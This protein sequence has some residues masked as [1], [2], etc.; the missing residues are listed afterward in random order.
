MEWE[1]STGIS[2]SG[3]QK[4]A[5]IQLAL[6]KS[7]YLLHVYSLKKLPAFFQNIL[8]SQ[9]IVKLGR[10]IGADFSK[11]A[12][13][14]PEIIPPT[15]HKKI[16]KGTIELGQLAFKKNVVP[17]GKAS[18]AAIVAAT[19]QKYLSKESRASEW[20]TITL[21]DDQ[22]QYAALDAYVALMIWEVL[23]NFEEA[24]KPLSSATK[25]GELV[26]LYVRKQEVA[27]GIIL[28]QPVSFL[29]QNPLPNEEPISLNVST[30]KTRALIQID[31]ILAPNC[32][33][34]HHRQSLKNL[35]NDEGSFKVVVS[36][37]SLRTRSDKEPVTIPEPLELR[38]IGTIKAIQP[39]SLSTEDIEDRD[40][41]IESDDDDEEDP[42]SE[43]GIEENVERSSGFTQQPSDI[44]PS[45]ILADVFHEIDKV[46]RTISKK[47][48]LCRKF[49]TAFSDTLLV[50]DEND[51]KVVSEILEKKGVSFNKIRSK[52]PAWLWKR[53]RR[54]IPEK[55]ILEL[56]LTE[57]FN[58]WGHIKCLVTGQKLFS[59]ETWKKTQGVLHDVRNGWL[60]DPG[61][62]SVY[63][64]E[65]MDKD[66][67]QL[68][69]CICGT[70]SVEGAIHNPIRRSFAS[71]NASP[72]LADALIA[73]F[74]HRHN[75]DA[76]SFHK[77]GVR[78]EGHYDP[79][80][81][82]EISK[83]RAD[84]SWTVTP[85]FSPSRLLQDRSS[86]FCTNKR[87][88]WDSKYSTHNKN[89]K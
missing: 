39:P 63:I 15:K 3:P 21:N 35:Q 23:E 52:S 9:Q 70:N 72:E 41:D 58:S 8:L 12:R 14:F 73:D 26:S 34:P 37:S 50:P 55:G 46:C 79:W 65:G 10:N 28:E 48:T 67:L 85:I 40:I 22:K 16:Y 1:F 78:Y 64:K 27:R 74:R 44:L 36:I 71:L 87:K 11:L 5:L 38:N 32:V 62:I 13:D 88:V 60:S 54:Y 4:T 77:A 19:L 81:D 47:H 75:T 24:G 49:A 43:R 20:A 84:I 45:R 31:T 51:K 7:V 18:L 25:V 33:I 80:L 53:V 6:P 57:F 66:G 82:H 17:N 2:G 68:Y 56:V 59:A 83:L 29:I 69:H 42:I 86:G 76:G 30:T 89:C 61:S